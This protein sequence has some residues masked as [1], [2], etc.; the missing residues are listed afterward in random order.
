MNTLKKLVLKG[1]VV[2]DKMDKTILVRTERKVKHKRYKK[3]ISRHTKYFV[4]DEINKC[5]V[6]DIVFFKEIAPI[7]KN[8]NWILV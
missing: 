3:I 5:K 8:K 1:V 2:S 6:G 4:H 7:S